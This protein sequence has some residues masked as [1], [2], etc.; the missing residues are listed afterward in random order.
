MTIG[1]GAD[2]QSSRPLVTEPVVDLARFY[3]PAARPAF[4]RGGPT[5]DPLETSIF[6]SF[7]K[8]R[9]FLALASAL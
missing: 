3:P 2:G 1:P 5:Q 9:H 8:L 6:I 4:E 7:N